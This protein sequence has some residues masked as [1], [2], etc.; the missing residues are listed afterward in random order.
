MGITDAQQGKRFFSVEEAYAEGDPYSHYAWFRE[1]DPVH[2]G[3]PGWPLGYPQIWL[4]RHADVMRLLRDPRLVKLVGDIPEIRALREVEPYEAPA[5][6]TFGFVANRMMLFQDPPDHTRLRGLAN[7]AFTPRVVA[8]RRG[9]IEALTR[10]LVRTLRDQGEGDLIEALSYPLPVLV[11]A[12]ILGVPAEDMHRFRD[13]ASVLGAAIDLPMEELATFTAR[14]D[15]S[16]RDMSDYLRSIVAKRRESPEDDLISRLI[17]ARD[18]D[19]RLTDDELIATCVLLMIAGHETTVNLIT[20][21]V[22]ALMRHRDQWD[23]LVADPSLAGSATEELLRYDSPVQL[24]TRITGESIEIGDVAVPRGTEIFFLLGSAN[25]DDAVWD[26]PD[27]VRIDRKVGRHMSFGMGI[28]FCL[29]APLA[30]LEGE[31]AFAT[32]A[33]DAP[34]M[35]LVDPNPTWRP[36]A[37]L[38]GLRRLDVCL[39]G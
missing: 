8:D 20:N 16:T 12:T 3:Q 24:T 38:H 5:Q 28:H 30:R 35:G 33:T 15:D 10:D 21:G 32:L 39:A 7:R 2:L 25:R 37:V 1:H 11:I 13:W 27:K 31:I 6:D 22:L 23:R 29:G 19:G 4:F 18:D 26:D 36:G 9:E 17:A 34:D 14:V